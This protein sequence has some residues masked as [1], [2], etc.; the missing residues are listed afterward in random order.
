LKDAGLIDAFNS[1][2]LYS[3][4]APKQSTLSG[5][6]HAD[7]IKPRHTPARSIEVPVDFFIQFSPVFRL[8]IIGGSNVNKLGYDLA[9]HGNAPRNAELWPLAWGRGVILMPKRPSMA[10]SVVAQQKVL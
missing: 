10:L 4:T 9:C 5:F 3:S 7:S 8:D 1:A 6:E 2:R